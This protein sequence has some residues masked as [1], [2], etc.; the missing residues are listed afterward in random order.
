MKKHLLFFT[1]LL[2]TMS[3]FSQEKIMLYPK[4]TKD[5][6]GITT[7][8]K[9]RDPEFLMDISE[10]RILAFKP[11]NPNGTAVLIC[12]GGGYV[13]VSVIKEGSEIA[14]WFNKLG[15]TA[16]VL[17]YRMPNGHYEISL[18]DAQTAM[19]YIRK[20]AKEYGINK[21][22]VGVMG[23][24]AG[25]HLAATLETQYTRST[26]PNFA[27]LGYPVITM[28][29]SFTHLGS[30]EHLIGKNP[31]E[32]LIKKYSSELNINKHTSPTFLF[33]AKDDGAVPVKN[34]QIFYDNLIKNNVPA[35]IHLYEKGGHGFGM[36]P[37][38]ID[39]DNWS[40][41]L[42]TWLEKQNLIP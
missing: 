10:P 37:K 15:V 28:D 41:A 35:E 24:S 6:N 39:S 5:S 14:Q 11:E 20:H 23:F 33:Q 30:R 8:E 40:E 4:G 31:S 9:W 36:R 16:F 12:P 13:G 18:E 3:L 19:K 34:S 22:K 27:I 32:K 2:M 42:K 21:K 17:Y 1:L 7:P 26:K 38:G 25:G 29:K